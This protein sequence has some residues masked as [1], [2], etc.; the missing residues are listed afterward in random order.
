LG[1][2]DAEFSDVTAHYLY[3]MQE[4]GMMYHYTRQ[5]PRPSCFVAEVY[6]STFHTLAPTS[7]YFRD[8]SYSLLSQYTLCECSHMAILRH[9][10]INLSC[11]LLILCRV[12][13]HVNDCRTHAS[14]PPDPSSQIR[15]IRHSF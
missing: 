6:K 3:N 11:H 4:Y 2:M 13:D 7:S 12:H 5:K 8:Q 14:S 9:S 15:L 1:T 10:S